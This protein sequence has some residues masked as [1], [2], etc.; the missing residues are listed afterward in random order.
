MKNQ[1][2][3]TLNTDDSTSWLQKSWRPIVML[4][5]TFIVVYAF[6]I[7]PAFLPKSMDVRSTLPTQ[8]WG[9]L[10]LGIGG[11]VI[12]RSVEKVADKV[13]KNGINLNKNKES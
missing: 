12:G 2:K 10:E 11:Y 4:S 1:E 7:Q 13:T 3:H 8:F 9:L 6:F 5:F